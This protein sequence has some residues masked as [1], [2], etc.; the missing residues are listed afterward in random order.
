MDLL[1]QMGSEDLDERNLQCWNF[2]VKEDAGQIQLNLET[3]VH[4]RSIYGLRKL[5]LP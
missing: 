3:N 5:V 4:I 2:A 1:P